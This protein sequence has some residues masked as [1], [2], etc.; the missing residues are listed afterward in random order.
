MTLW[1]YTSNSQNWLTLCSKNLIHSEALIRLKIYSCWKQKQK[2]L[3]NLTKNVMQHNSNTHCLNTL[4]ISKICQN[5]RNTF[6][7]LFWLIYLVP[8]NHPP[9]ADT[10]TSQGTAWGP[11]T[12]RA[13]PG[14]HSR[15]RRGRDSAPAP[16]AR[17]ALSLPALS[18]AGR[19]AGVGGCWWPVCWDPLS[20][21]LRLSWASL[22]HPHCRERH[23]ALVRPRPARLLLGFLPLVATGKAPRLW[24]RLLDTELPDETEEK[25][26]GYEILLLFSR[27]VRGS[28]PDFGRA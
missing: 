7:T 17:P 27:R 18:L 21:P 1:N 11:E 12:W 5:L 15:G 16:R 4:S 14:A 13:R 20:Q 3:V 10:P 22:R 25:C 28:G 6:K 8:Q 23:L 24:F 2:P 19:R 26:C 9:R